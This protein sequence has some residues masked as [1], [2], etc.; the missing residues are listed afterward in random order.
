MGNLTNSIGFLTG[1]FDISG[2]VDKPNVVGTLDFNEIGFK[3]T[4][5]NSSFKS[6][7]DQIKFTGESIVF[8]NFGIKDEK[9]NDLNIN[10]RI[11]TS[12]FQDFQ[13]DL[14][15]VA[16]NFKAINSTAK[17][18][19]L[20]YGELYFDTKL[21]IKGDL[22][23]PVINGS[24]KVNEDTKFTVVLPQSDPSIA[25]REG[26]VEF[27]DP[28]TVKLFDDALTM[29]DS[30]NTT[31]IRGILAAVNIEIDKEAEFSIIID[32]A[33]GDFLRLKGE[34]QLSG[35][36]DPSG[37]TTLTGRYEFTEGSYEMN[38]NLIKRKFD[39]KSGSYILWT[40]EPTSAN[41]NIT[42]V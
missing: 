8:D 35:G 22:D 31:D 39:I 19:D 37:K 18:S 16:D 40:G 23:R 26:I 20:F 7:N 27:I 41:I 24:L 17:D 3:V 5:L 32:K 15:V 1:N 14:A 38:F 10:G 30:L 25:D 42:A 29:K 34:A 13:F 12:T 28:N 4:S 36:I 33:N 6:I 21:D 11:L 2:T 9:N